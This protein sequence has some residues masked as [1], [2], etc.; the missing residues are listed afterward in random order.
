MIGLAQTL[1]DRSTMAFG[2][3]TIDILTRRRAYF[4][5]SGGKSQ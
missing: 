5:C 3:G 1:L 4:R 2:E